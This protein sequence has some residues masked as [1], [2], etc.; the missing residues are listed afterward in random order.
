[1]KNIMERPLTL[2]NSPMSFAP[3]NELGVVFLFPSLLKK[4]QFKI[5]KIGNSFPDCIAYRKSGNKEKKI[6]IEFEFRAS[7][8]IQHKHNIRKCDCI[9][10]WENDWA[11]CPIEI[12]E[13]KK[14]FGVSRK[15][16]IQPVLKSQCHWL[17]EYD[18]LNWSLSKRVTTGDILLMYRCSPYKAITD[19]FVYNG[20]SLS[21]RKASWRTGNANFGDIKRISKLAAPVYFE[22]LK[23]HKVLSTSGFVRRQLQGN[24]L[25]SEYWHYLFEM[26]L[27]RNSLLA[28]KLSKISPEKL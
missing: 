4:L 16:W 11:D 24:C 21:K 25:V 15:V 12:I 23:K 28:K 8:F 20:I 2:L 19:I 1:M 26:I 14:Y 18:T 27:N 13:I 17:D 9:V 5:E 10:C 3:E 7:N 6:R 22:D